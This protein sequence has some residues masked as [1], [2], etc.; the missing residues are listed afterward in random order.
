MSD[1]N[2]IALIAALLAIVASLLGAVI[3]FVFL[4]TARASS[5]ILNHDKRTLSRRI[6]HKYLTVSL[7]YGD[8]Q[9]KNLS[10]GETRE[11]YLNAVEV[12]CNLV[13]LSGTRSRLDK[14]QEYEVTA[15]ASALRLFR[16]TLSKCREDWT[17]NL[18]EH[19][20]K[21]A[22]L[23]P[24]M[25]RVKE[26][27][28]SEIQ[29]ELGQFV[30]ELVISLQ[31]L[32]TINI[33]IWSNEL[34]RLCST[35]PP[36]DRYSHLFRTWKRITYVSRKEGFAFL[37]GFMDST[38]KRILEEVDNMHRLNERDPNTYSKLENVVGCLNEFQEQCLRWNGQKLANWWLTIHSLIISY[39]NQFEERDDA[40]LRSHQEYLVKMTEEIISLL[41]TR[42]DVVNK[43]AKKEQSVPIMD[44][45]DSLCG[46]II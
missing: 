11:A 32:S 16:I 4:S 44:P 36:E 23:A 9:I 46:V 31:R 21:F 37:S 15:I 41:S 18:S 34:Q 1:P 39:M 14:L 42:P 3:S 13:S 22:S 28:R 33:K 27:K 43:P 19:I 35:I 2:T 45:D 29:E 7:P 30:C 38:L 5:G 20:F 17:E 8:R 24:S 26:L 25:L 40:L 12:C 6:S 10:L